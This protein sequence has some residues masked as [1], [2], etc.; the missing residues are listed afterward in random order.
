MLTFFDASGDHDVGAWLRTL[1]AVADTGQPVALVG[2]GG[3]CCLQGRSPAGR[4][5]SNVAVRL[6]LPPVLRKRF[7]RRTPV[8][9]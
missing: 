2:H 7:V 6:A 1:D 5:T 9:A 8:S 3:K 4:A